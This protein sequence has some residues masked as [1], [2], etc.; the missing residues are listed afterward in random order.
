MIEDIL[1]KN[2]QT[3]AEAQFAFEINGWERIDSI[4][5]DRQSNSTAWGI[6]YTKNGKKF[7]LNID[8]AAT[9]LQVA[10]RIP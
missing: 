4:Q 5:K 7:Y 2:L 1:K 3:L 9:A 6:L 10:K 8:S